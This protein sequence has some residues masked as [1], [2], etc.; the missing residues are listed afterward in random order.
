MINS[1]FLAPGINK[2]RWETYVR[3]LSR[4]LNHGGWLQMAEWGYLIQSENGTLHANSYCQRWNDLYREA[5]ENTKD[6]RVGPKLGDLMRR[7]GLKDVV[8][9]G[10]RIPIGPWKEGMSGRSISFL[11]LT[12][13]LFPCANDLRPHDMQPSMLFLPACLR[14]FRA[15]QSGIENM[16]SLCKLAGINCCPLSFPIQS[17]PHLLVH[18]TNGFCHQG[19]RTSV[20]STS[21]SSA[22]HWSL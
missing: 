17:N 12:L 11:L 8:T 22:K 7:V 18:K 19:G 9:R 1:R 2:R 14:R 6:L 13:G 5:L 15:S 3:D 4:L 16:I 21:M 10:D 20:V